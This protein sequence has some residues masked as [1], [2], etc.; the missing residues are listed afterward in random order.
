MFFYGMTGFKV[1]HTVPA[2]A[3]RVKVTARQWS[4]LF[5]YGNGKKS[6]DLVVPQGGAVSLEMTSTDVIHSFFAPAYRV[7]QD[8]LP[9]ITT[10]VW[11]R[12]AELGSTDILCT[13]YCGLQHSKM[14]SR[15]VVVPPAEFDDWLA[16][17]EVSIPEL[18]GGD[19]NAPVMLLREHGCLDCHS[20]DGK[21]LVGP[22]LKG[23]Y[24]SLAEVVTGGVQRTVTADDEY[25][26][27]S[28]LEP[29]T[30]VVAGYEN[31]MP[32]ASAKDRLTDDEIH[33]V[34]EYLKTLR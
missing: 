5:E 4:W 18:A 15:V 24:G 32:K 26:R 12:A 17:R 2:D 22:T 9:G 7:K 3:M 1:L 33:E 8:V 30:D 34:V 31:I 28:I 19:A 20:L 16:G 6:P 10:R 25:I 27:T 13:Q 14:L 23:L 11:F 21:K 29:G